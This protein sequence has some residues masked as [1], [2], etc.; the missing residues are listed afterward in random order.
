[1]KICVVGGGAREVAV[2]RTLKKSP[3]CK[4]LI[5]VANHQNPALQVASW[6]C[7]ISCELMLAVKVMIHCPPVLIFFVHQEICSAYKVSPVDDVDA[8]VTFCQSEKVCISQF[9]SPAVGPC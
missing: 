8:I 2:A 9:V 4:E 1:M 7:T 5:A 3:K 6:H